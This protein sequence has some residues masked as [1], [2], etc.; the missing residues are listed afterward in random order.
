MG[1]RSGCPALSGFM[2]RLGIDLWIYFGRFALQ[3]WMEIGHSPCKS[4]AIHILLAGPHPGEQVIAAVDPDF[5]INVMQ[6]GFDGRDRNKQLTG[7]IR[8]AFPLDNFEYD[9]TLPPGD[10]VFRQESLENPVDLDR[11]GNE[12]IQE[13]DN[14]EDAIQDV[15]D[16]AVD[17]VIFRCE[18][19]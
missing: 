10:T 11:G 14:D 16:R 6:V 2:R 5:R 9:L 1:D 4:P 7:D 12:V 18:S 13:I 15:G 19:R 17:K 8:V 3:L